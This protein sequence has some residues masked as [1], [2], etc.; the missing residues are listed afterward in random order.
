M[1]R[2]PGP[3]RRA[4]DGTLTQRALLQA[5][6]RAAGATFRWPYRLPH[7]RGQHVAGQIE[8]GRG[9]FVGRHAWLNMNEP[10]ARLVIGPGCVIGNDFSVTCA[11]LV[12]IGSGVLMSSRVTLLDQVHDFASW[13]APNLA[14]TTPE[15]PHFSWAMTSP[16][17]VR[18]GSGSWIG[19]GVVVLPGVTIGEGCVVGANA[20]VTRDIPAYSVAAGVP[21]AV[22]RRLCPVE[23]E[24][25]DRA[26]PGPGH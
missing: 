19:I 3:G 16:R 17:P 10:T 22:V 14:G 4:I 8:L 26:H 11:E 15:A 21:A 1:S 7:Q 2:S 20:V 9:V 18:V 12:E 13:L 24:G 6:A 23:A 5:R 25:D